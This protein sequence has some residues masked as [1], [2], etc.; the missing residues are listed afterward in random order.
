MKIYNRTVVHKHLSLWRACAWVVSF[1]AIFTSYSVYLQ[2]SGKVQIQ[3]AMQTNLFFYKM[4][5]ALNSNCRRTWLRMSDAICVVLPPGDAHISKTHS[6]GWGLS[7]WPTTTDG[8]FCGKIS[9]GS[10]PVKHATNSLNILLTEYILC[11]QMTRV[12]IDCAALMAVAAEQACRQ[13]QMDHTPDKL[14]V[15]YTGSVI[16][17]PMPLKHVQCSQN[18][19]PLKYAVNIKIYG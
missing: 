4:Y 19:T 16:S 9:S 3:T 14:R 7:T 13:N 1:T 11:M 12:R 8:K 5:I 17:I 10:K 2:L 6:P 15:W 18:L